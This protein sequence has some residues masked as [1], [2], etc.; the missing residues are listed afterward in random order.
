MCFSED[1]LGDESPPVC[2]LAAMPMAIRLSPPPSRIPCHTALPKRHLWCLSQRMRHFTLSLLASWGPCTA[3]AKL[4]VCLPPVTATLACLLS[5]LHALC[6]FLT[7]LPLLLE[8]QHCPAT[9]LPT[10]PLPPQGLL[11]LLRNLKKDSEEFRVLML[12]LDNSGKTTALK[13]LA[14]VRLCHAERLANVCC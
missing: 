5:S 10:L 9:Y 12:G 7:S 2:R 1:C 13:K 4:D 14:G 3:A 6:P 8:R 11:S